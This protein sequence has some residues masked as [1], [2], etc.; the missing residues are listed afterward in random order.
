MESVGIEQKSRVKPQLEIDLKSIP[1]S[2]MPHH[3]QPM[4]ATL[5]HKPFDKDGWLFEI[6]WDGW[7]AL[8]EVT[9]SHVRLYSRND[10]TLNRCFN[11][12][13]EALS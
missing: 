11:T 13:V 6:K 10:R 12:V 2:D 4:L 8:A 1:E 3:V 5:V 9:H 7:R